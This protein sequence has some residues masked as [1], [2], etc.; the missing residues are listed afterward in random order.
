M[1]PLEVGRAT[2]FNRGAVEPKLGKRV[3]VDPVLVLRMRR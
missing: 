3:L 1:K 2:P